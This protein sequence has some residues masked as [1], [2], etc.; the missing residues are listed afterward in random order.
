MA[1]CAHDHKEPQMCADC[2]L[3]E[4]EWESCP[5]RTCAKGMLDAHAAAARREAFDFCNDLARA[6]L[7]VSEFRSRFLHELSEARAAERGER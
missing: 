3:D 6:Y 2:R 4:W 1:D 7:P 5:D